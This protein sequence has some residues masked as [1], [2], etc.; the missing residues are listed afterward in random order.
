MNSN[1]HI[2]GIILAGGKSSR[3]GSDK[4]FLLLNEKAFIQ[5]IIEAMQPLVKDIIIVSNNSDYD[6]LNLKRVNDLIENS[7]PLAGIYSGLHH[8]NTENNLVLSCDVPLINTETLKKLT[9]N[10]EEHIDVIQLESKGKT[11]PLIAMYKTHCKNKFFELLQQ[12]E[13][14]LR[15]AV[16]QCKV[17]TITLNT[18]LEKFTVNINTQH[19][20]RDLSGFE[21]L[22]G[23]K[24]Q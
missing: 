1:K 10:I 15:F 5:H 14:R 22:T 3:I 21:N 17:K 2:T 23:L 16:K 19:H 8:S 7:G 24:Q 9:A 12:G 11:M 13:K 20:L 6:I 18:E 4:G